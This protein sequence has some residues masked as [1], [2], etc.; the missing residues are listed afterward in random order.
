[1]TFKGGDV[2]LSD[3]TNYIPLEQAVEQFDVQ[4]STLHRDIEDGIVRAVQ[5]AGNV[6]VAAEDVATISEIPAPSEEMMGQPIRAKEAVEKYKINSHSLLTMWRQRGIIIALVHE[7][8]NV[9]YDE[10]TVASAARIYHA[11]KHS[12]GIRYPRPVS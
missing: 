5:V 3:L 2:G 7:H 11:S 12:K 8:M 6:A 10:Y 1:V 9:I 4:E